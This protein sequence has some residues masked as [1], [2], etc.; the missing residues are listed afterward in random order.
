MSNSQNNN[1]SR[2][3]NPNAYSTNQARLPRAYGHGH[4]DSGQTTSQSQSPSTLNPSTTESILG[5]PDLGNTSATTFAGGEQETDFGQLAGLGF[6]PGGPLVWDEWNNPLDFGDFSTFYQPQGELA[7]ELQSQRGIVGEFSNPIPVRQERPILPPP[8]IL[9]PSQTQFPPPERPKPVQRQNSSSGRADNAYGSMP[10]PLSR[11]PSMTLPSNTQTQV[12]EQAGS[13]SRSGAS[14]PRTGAK[15]KADAD[16]PSSRAAI[17]P[18]PPKRPSVSRPSGHSQSPR[19]TRSHANAPDTD[20][21]IDDDTPITRKDSESMQRSV[22]G[23]KR[24][25]ET[26]ESSQRIIPNIARLTTVLPAGKVFPI[27]IGSELFRLSGASLSSD[28]QF[29]LFPYRE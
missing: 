29:V 16:T 4:N 25:S 15:R 6:P 21:P 17:D 14:A 3:L 22:S 12:A 10:S 11:T 1:T 26:A 8:E 23:T 2:N 20:T 27:Q 7:Q 5:D 24:K 18:S 9:A 13:R 28:G 19:L